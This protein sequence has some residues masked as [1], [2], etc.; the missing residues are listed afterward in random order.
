EAI[1]RT[2]G[3]NTWASTRSAVRRP[4]QSADSTAPPYPQASERHNR[5]DRWQPPAAESSTVQDPARRAP[6][7]RE[8]VSRR[9]DRI[10]FPYIDAMLTKLL[11]AYSTV[12]TTLLAAFTLTGSV[13]ARVQHFDEIHVH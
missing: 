3:A 6:R 13:T 2:L 10:R 5:P 12:V 11:V 4:P 8:S 9:T 1:V 7:N